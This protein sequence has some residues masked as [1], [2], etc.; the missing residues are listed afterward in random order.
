MQSDTSK[1]QHAVKPT[2]IVKMPRLRNH[3]L[4]L[5]SETDI[6]VKSNIKESKTEESARPLPLK[7]S[8]KSFSSTIICSSQEIGPSDAEN[9]KTKPRTQLP[10]PQN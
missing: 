4:K 3:D 9:K 6:K 8:N 2:K 7:E 10:L 5:T 1:T